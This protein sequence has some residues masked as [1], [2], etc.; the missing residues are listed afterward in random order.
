MSV[1]NVVKTF[2]LEDNS[3]QV[4]FQKHKTVG[5]RTSLHYFAIV[6]LIIYLLHLENFLFKMHLLNNYLN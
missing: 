2:D 3:T 6:N 1:Y 4:Q 5:D